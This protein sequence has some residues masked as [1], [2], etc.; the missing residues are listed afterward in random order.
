MIDTAIIISGGLG[1]RLRPLTDYTPKP[2]L[3]IKG[4]PTV[5]HIIENLKK[6]G[7]KQIIHSVGYKA[8][9]IEDY[10][11]AK[12]LGISIKHIK[13]DEPLGTGGAIKLASKGLN[14]PF[15]LTWGD[16]LMDINW[17]ELHKM[18]LKNNSQITMA[19]TPREDVE[20]FGV[21]KLEGE[22]IISFVEKPKR[23]LAPSNLINAG[24]FVIDPK[25]LSILPEGVSSIERDCFEK[26]APLGKISAYIHKGQWFP[27]DTLEKYSLACLNFIPEI[28]L[29]EK[30][31]IIADVDDTIC[32]S[33]QVIYP[34]MAEQIN[35]L[36]SQGYAIAF[37][38]GSKCEHLYGMISSKINGEHHLLG[39][40][41]TIYEVIKDGSR[42]QVYANNLTNS[43]KKEIFNAFKRLILQFNI[44]PM[45]S[46]EDQLQD[47]DSQI[48]LSALGRNAPPETKRDYDPSEEKRKWWVEFLKGYLDDNKYEIKIGGTTSIDVTRKGM[49]KELGIKKFAEQLGMPLSKILFIGDK[50]YPGGNDYPASRIVDCI[51]VKSPKETLE[52][53]RKLP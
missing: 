29:N 33:C 7:V 50:I 26:L 43:E 45:T 12:S 36:I 35:R 24:A 52:V 14:R 31:V 21:A 44:K 49:D 9:M 37:I 5:Q 47:R 25:C 13:E 28:N 34:E 23:E 10:F 39:N 40:T 27:T 46:T 38:S 19:L 41:G 6:H 8:Q 30:K 48:T 16:N 32:E 51:S 2:L 11:K 22:R 53:L 3:P 17:T 20:N 15:F 18:Y 1:T 4:K 42:K